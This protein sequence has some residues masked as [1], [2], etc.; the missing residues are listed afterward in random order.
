MNVVATEEIDAI[1]LVR[2]NEAL[3]FVEDGEWIKG[4][5]AGLEALSG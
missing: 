2:R 3:D 4:A 1:E 5:D